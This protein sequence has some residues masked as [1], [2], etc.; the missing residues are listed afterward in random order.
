MSGDERESDYDAK[1]GAN[2]RDVFV[3][4]TSSRVAYVAEARSDMLFRVANGNPWLGC[5]RL[6]TLT[7]R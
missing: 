7:S 6:D 5:H 2:R 3:R 1:S 4:L